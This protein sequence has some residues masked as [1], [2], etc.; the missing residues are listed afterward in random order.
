[1]RPYPSY[2]NNVY[3]PEKK[4]PPVIRI[5]HGARD[6]PVILT[7]PGWLGRLD[8]KKFRFSAPTHTIETV[9][10]R[11]RWIDLPAFLVA[12]P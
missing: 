6:L 11:E 2:L 7:K 10:F 8:S 9:Q 3:D 1:M 5:L 12:H 4:P